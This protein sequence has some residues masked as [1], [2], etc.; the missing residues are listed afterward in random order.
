M[1]A[2]STDVVHDETRYKYVQN[3]ILALSLDSVYC[4][5][6]TIFESTVFV[7]DESATPGF[8]HFF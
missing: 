5:T 6:N 2:K 3:L 8:I 1:F 7:Q 4:A